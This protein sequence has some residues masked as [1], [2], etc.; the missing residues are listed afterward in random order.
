MRTD[1]PYE[2]SISGEKREMARLL[3]PVAE[4]ARN[5]AEGIVLGEVRREE[6]AVR[7][8]RGLRDRTD[9]DR[10]DRNILAVNPKVRERRY[11]GTKR[12]SP[13]EYLPDVR[14]VHLQAVLVFVRLE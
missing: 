5:D 6:S 9:D 2:N 8:L 7:G 12:Y 10:N 11:A 13:F 1:C 14:E 4:I 3:G